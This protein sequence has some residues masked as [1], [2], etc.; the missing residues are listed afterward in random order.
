ML[1]ENFVVY[2]SFIF[3]GPG[4]VI[5]Q[6]GVRG[7]RGLGLGGA[8]LCHGGHGGAGHHQ[9]YHHRPYGPFTTTAA[10]ATING[11]HGLF[12][13]AAHPARHP[14]T[15]CWPDV[16]LAG[17]GALG[18]HR[19]LAAGP[20]RRAAPP[21]CCTCTT[22][23]IGNDS[24]ESLGGAPRRHRQGGARGS[25]TRPAHAGPD[26]GWRRCRPSRPQAGVPRPAAVFGARAGA[27]LGQRDGQAAGD[28]RRGERGRGAGVVVGGG[29]RRRWACPDAAPVMHQRRGHLRSYPEPANHS[30]TRAAA[31][32]TRT[33]TA[34]HG[35]LPAF[36]RRPGQD[37]GTS[38][39]SAVGRR[40][41]PPCYPG[42]AVPRSSAGDPVDRRRWARRW[43]SQRGKASVRSV[44]SFDTCK[45][46]RIILPLPTHFNNNSISTCSSR[47]ATTTAAASCTSS[48]S[49][50]APGWCDPS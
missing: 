5:F 30:T 43:A 7:G 32:A 36:V 29:R 2:D 35:R 38:T 47:P 21:C 15:G 19:P 3:N 39:T 20:R 50:G 34:G 16:G 11:R 33:R 44:Q 24:H 46:K 14:A 26:L 1:K 25:T 8:G 49:P 27:Q 10:G 13:D 48:P 9:G 41:E 18:G 17:F 23:A 42:A 22:L 4:F 40:R 12:G 28:G 45:T 31:A 6:S 37:G